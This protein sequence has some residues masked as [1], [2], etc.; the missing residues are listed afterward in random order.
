MTRSTHIL[1]LVVLTLLIVPFFDNP[2]LQAANCTFVLGFQAIH[3]QIPDI[4]G[5]CLVDQHYNPANGDALQETTGGMLVWRKADNFTAFTDGY[6]SWVNGPYGLQQRLNSERFAWENDPLTITP[7]MADFSPATAIQPPTTL[8][9]E[10]T[11]SLS[12]DLRASYTMAI[13]VVGSP[14][15]PVPN[16]LMAI[17]ENARRGVPQ[18]FADATYSRLKMNTGPAVVVLQLAQATTDGAVIAREFFRT[19]ADGYDFIAV[20]LAYELDL[21][22]AGCFYSPVKNDVLGTGLGQ[23]DQTVRYGS[24]GGLRGVATCG[25]AQFR[26]GGLVGD[27]VHEIGHAWFAYARYLSPSGER[28]PLANSSNHW[29][30]ILGPSG[31]NP[32]FRYGAGK[33]LVPYVVQDQSGNF[34][35]ETSPVKRYSWLELYLMGLARKE[36]VP[37]ITKLIGNPPCEFKIQVEFQAEQ[38]TAKLAGTDPPGCGL[39]TQAISIDQII[40]VEG[41]VRQID[42]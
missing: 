41:P 3:D 14:E 12:P 38:A 42:R 11:L 17:A 29:G 23:I 32:S 31:F 7:P 4:V 10:P 16:D 20:G 15:H 26:A 2:P 28:L 9:P 27:L 40:D 6:Q 24:D 18:V 33:S 1:R 30:S 21:G 5:D 34:K 19:N 36:E 13:V 22:N 37:P 25:L 39:T 35:V 8:A